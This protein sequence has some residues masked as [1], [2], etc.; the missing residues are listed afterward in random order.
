MFGEDLNETLS[1]TVNDVLFRA[2]VT[3]VQ[4]HIID[5]LCMQG[6]DHANAVDAIN[7]QLRMCSAALGED[8]KPII[9]PQE[10]FNLIVFKNMRNLL[11]N[12]PLE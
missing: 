4:H 11:G 5:A 12:K 1:K 8:K 2:R 10:H 3:L 9:R 7:S 6:K